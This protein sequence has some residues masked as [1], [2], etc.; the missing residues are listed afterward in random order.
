MKC[1]CVCVCLRVCDVLLACY[2]GMWLSLHG[3]FIQA[4]LDG[5]QASFCCRCCIQFVLGLGYV[6]DS[7]FH[8]SWTHLDTLRHFATENSGY[9]PVCIAMLV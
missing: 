2:N 7:A 9:P 1:L 8:V 5:L 4:S 6:R 3:C